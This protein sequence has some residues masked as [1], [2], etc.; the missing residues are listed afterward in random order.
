[1]TNRLVKCDQCDTV[2]P[3]VGQVIHSN[4]GFDDEGNQLTQ[5]FVFCVDCPQD[6]REWSEEI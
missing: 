3:I 1:M 5:T 4:N 6:L 2:N